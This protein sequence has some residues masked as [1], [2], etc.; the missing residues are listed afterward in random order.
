MGR[1]WKEVDRV[2]SEINET[3]ENEMGFYRWYRSIYPITVDADM[4][5]LLEKAWRQSARE[6]RE[7]NGWQPIETAPKDGTDIL[8]FDVCE[9]CVGRWCAGDWWIHGGDVTASDA[10]YWMSLPD[11]PKNEVSG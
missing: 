1:S 5:V 4:F 8:I 9:V 10:T 11:A 7:A 2:M 3:I 6:E